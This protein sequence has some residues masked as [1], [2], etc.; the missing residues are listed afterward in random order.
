MKRKFLW[1]AVSENTGDTSLVFLKSDRIIY[2]KM[3]DTIMDFY[4]K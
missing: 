3:I 4:T 2:R 1:I